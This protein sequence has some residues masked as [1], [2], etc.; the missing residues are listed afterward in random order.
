[1]AAISLIPRISGRTNVK[2]SLEGGLTSKGGTLEWGM[3]REGG[4][5]E[6]SAA[7]T[8]LLKDHSSNKQFKKGCRQYSFFWKKLVG[9]PPLEGGVPKWGWI[10]DTA[11]DKHNFF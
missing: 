1:M 6:F 5:A 9:T 10:S 8:V 7:A 11:R 4:T 2:G 3:S